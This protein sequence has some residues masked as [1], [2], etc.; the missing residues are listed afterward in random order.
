MPTRNRHNG[1]AQSS[2]G[3]TQPASADDETTTDARTISPIPFVTQPS[4][5]APEGEASP[6]LHPPSVAAARRPSPR[7]GRPGIRR[8][9]KRFWLVR[10]KERWLAGE[11]DESAAS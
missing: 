4:T 2:G 11:V 5:P 8:D 1:S 9:A 3:R 10:A 6:P 7:E